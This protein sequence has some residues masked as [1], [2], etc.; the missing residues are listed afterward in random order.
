MFTWT[1]SNFLV[2]RGGF[3]QLD[4]VS[5][6]ILCEHETFPMKFL[7]IPGFKTRRVYTSSNPELP[8]ICTLGAKDYWL[9]L[10]MIFVRP[11]K[12]SMRCPAQ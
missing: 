12:E 1:V 11:N 5:R 8:L 3:K 9:A 10:V 4:T 6:F 2:S 7:Q